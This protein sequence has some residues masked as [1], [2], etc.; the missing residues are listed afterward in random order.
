MLKSPVQSLYDGLVRHRFSFVISLISLGI[1]GV[2][3]AL[4]PA[5]DNAPEAISSSSGFPIAAGS[6]HYPEL[7]KETTP[8]QQNNSASDV[9]ASVPLEEPLPLP[10]AEGHSLSEPALPGTI[11]HVPATTDISSDKRTVPTPPATSRLTTAWTANAASSPSSFDKP[12]IAIV[13][14]DLGIDRPRSQQ[15]MELPASLTMSFLPYASHLI[16]QVEFGRS[17]GHEFLVH[18]PMEAL[19]SHND[20]GPD[21][22]TIDLA[23][24]EIIRRLDV[25]LS[26]FT[27]YIG[28]NN[29]MGSRFTMDAASLAPVMTELQ[30]RGLLFLDSRTAPRSIAAATAIDFGVA[31]VARDVFIDHIRTPEAVREQLQVL[32][33]I[34]LKKGTAIGIG[35]PDDGTLEALREWI[36]M[37]A[38]RG[39]Q[40]VPLS[41]VAKVRLWDRD[42][43]RLARH[44]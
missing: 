19:D 36:P 26:K 23:S 34:A 31:A 41:V 43:S 9:T 42:Q 13:I 21:A 7:P 10:D 5:K 18:I 1:I 3:L 37:V 39:F 38:N 27:G 33:H 17:Q 22:L 40:L 30:Q 24:D 25:A 12:L 11:I 15:A 44:P 28:I 16:E 20:P 35:H 14:D 4:L 8:P 32:E 29:H 6:I 2:I